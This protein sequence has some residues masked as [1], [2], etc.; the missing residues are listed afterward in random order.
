MP[1]ESEIL[2][3]LEQ[4]E[5]LA[6]RA[7]ALTGLS[8]LAGGA[9]RAAVQIVRRLEAAQHPEGHW[10][11]DLPLNK[12][13]QTAKAPLDD[14]ALPLLLLDQCRREGA[15]VRDDLARCWTVVRR[16]A[17]FLVRSGPVTASDRWGQGRGYAP[18]TLATSIVALLAAADWAD[19]HDPL[20]AS[21]LRDTADYWNDHVEPWTYATDTG[22][23]GELGI[24]GYYV[25]LAPDEFPAEATACLVTDW[26]E[27]PGADCL[28]LVRYGLRAPD[29][30]RILA[31]VRAV[32]ALLATETPEGPAWRVRAD[33]RPCPLLTAERAHYE[34][35]AGRR[36]Q[37]KCL[38]RTAELL[39]RE[40]SCAGE[41]GA[42]EGAAIAWVQ[43]ELRLLER[44]LRDGQVY[45]A[46]P[47]AA[48]RY[49]AG[50][51]QSP[52][53]LW[54]FDRPLAAMPAGKTL[55]FELM[56]PGRV[57]WTPNRW[58]SYYDTNT[59]DA[60]L[61]VH[62]ADLSVEHLRPGDQVDFTFYWPAVPKWE[63]RDFFIDVTEH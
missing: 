46:P 56:H 32:D 58:R 5:E 16:A 29:D 39:A 2:R 38:T 35:A 48:A 6:P 23:A 10:G 34:L 62:V 7:V 11:R 13:T 1:A 40:A 27:S 44:S 49:R 28:G 31:S 41:G 42:N 53:A 51:T 24:E 8:L 15:L 57:R 3:T 50:R 22:L 21:Y 37:A 59:R 26:P 47:Y 14:I 4:S 54:R 45:A 33:G 52:H 43:A 55:R 25:R 20:A 60:G 30:P 17:G 12:A 63:G 36:E 18:S 9:R 19:Q 61:G